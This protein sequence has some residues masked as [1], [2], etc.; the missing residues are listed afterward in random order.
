MIWRLL[1]N[2][3]ERWKETKD[4]LASLVASFVSV[5]ECQWRS[6]RALVGGR[7]TDDGWIE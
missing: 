7:F 6:D 2:V 5:E 1:S 3:T 4:R